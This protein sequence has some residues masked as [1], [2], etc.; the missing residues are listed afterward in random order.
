MSAG[1]VLP[2]LATA[3]LSAALALSLSVPPAT[4]ATVTDPELIVTLELPTGDVDYDLELGRLHVFD[5]EDTPF[6]VSVIDGCSVNDHLW[7][8]G[9]GLSGIPVPLTVRDLRSGRS[10]RTVLPAYEPGV[11]IGTVI[12][13]EALLV[14]GDD[15]PGGLPALSGTA[16]LTSADGRGDDYPDSIVVRSDGSEDGY[17]RLVR[18]GSSFPII[19]KGSPVV[20]VDESVVYDELVLLAEGRTPRKIEGVVFRGAEGML[21]DRARL[22]RVLKGIDRSRVRRAFE[23]AKNV[24]VPQGLIDELGLTG[25]DQIHHLSL[26]LD[27]IGADAYLAKAGWIRERGRPIEPP[28]PVDARFSVKTARASGE[29]EEIPLVGPLVGSEAAGRLWEHRSAGVLVQIVDACDLGGSFWTLAGAATDE[30]LELVITDT[31]SGGTATYLLWTDREDVSRLSDSA[32]L[33]G[34]P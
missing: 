9:A 15:P 17:R 34:C 21:P 29:T 27:T 24:R 7:V 1:N 25:V 31:Q 4:L 16:T 12:E 30:P 22:E 5:E 3:A 20:A 10:A 28:V 19:S 23:T 6:V 26:D 33:T 32:S 2:R 18:G 13:P 8:V 11:P 14:C